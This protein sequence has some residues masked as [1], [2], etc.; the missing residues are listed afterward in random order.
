MQQRALGAK[1]FYFKPNRDGEG[2]TIGA[3]LKRAQA[4]GPKA[5]YAAA[6]DPG[7]HRTD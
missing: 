3:D 5:K 4:L 2:L 6:T 7:L 1:D